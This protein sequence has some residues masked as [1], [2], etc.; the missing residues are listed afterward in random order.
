MFRIP[1]VAVMAGLCSAVFCGCLSIGPTATAPWATRVWPGVPQP[2]PSA[3]PLESD[4][5]R[6]GAAQTYGD[7]KTQRANKPSTDAPVIEGNSRTE[8]GTIVIPRRA[9]PPDSKQKSGGWTP[10]ELRKLDGASAAGPALE[11]P[12][13]IADSRSSLSLVVEVPPHPS[14]GRSCAFDLTLINTGTKSLAD[15]VVVADLGPGL[16]LPGRND[17]RVQVLVGALDVAAKRSLQLTVIAGRSG[18]LGCRFEVVQRKQTLLTKQMYL[19]VSTAA[20]DIKIIGPRRRTLGS[21]SEFLVR[22]TNRGRRAIGDLDLV[23]NHSE[24]LELVAATEHATDDQ[25]A[26]VWKLETLAAGESVTFQLEYVCQRISEACHVTAVASAKGFGQVRD[27]GTLQI[28]PVTGNLDLTVQDTE[29]PV[30]VG[31][32]CVFRTAVKNLG[33]QPL[34]QVQVRIKLPLECRIVKIVTQIR[35]ASSKV[36]YRVSGREVLFDS[37]PVLEAGAS[38]SFDVRVK[39]LRPGD[40]AFQAI[41]RHALST[42]SLVAREPTTFLP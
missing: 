14:V 9:L 30:Q 33:L 42:V 10:T 32:E 11:L 35:D 37:V 28:V 20:L 17:R 1:F 3:T 23:I 29:D 5:A 27:N 22:L 38:V 21:R 36:P 31:Q 7:A 25:G 12:Q 2:N 39:T 6:H 41:A 16:A 24:A 13:S 8:G 26:R 15:V 18:R 34:R 4:P 40:V 19:D